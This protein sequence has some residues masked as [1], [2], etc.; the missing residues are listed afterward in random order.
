MR[1]YIL[2]FQVPD[3]VEFKSLDN[4]YE[5]LNNGEKSE[6]SKAK[7]GQELFHDNSN[8][9]VTCESN[10]D[11]RKAWRNKAVR[12]IP[13]PGQVRRLPGPGLGYL[14]WKCIGLRH[15]LLPSDQ[16]L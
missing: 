14:W 8:E 3:I 12:F 7:A 2:G 9:V 4:L 5:E 13:L 11:R 10:F 1:R 16:G 6:A 15:D